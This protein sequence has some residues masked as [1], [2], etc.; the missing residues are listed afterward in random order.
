MKRGIQG[1][2]RREQPKLLI[3]MSVAI[4][5]VLESFRNSQKYN[6]Y[7]REISRGLIGTEKRADVFSLWL[8]L[9]VLFGPDTCHSRAHESRLS[10]GL[11]NG[12][13]RP[14]LAVPRF[15]MEGG[16]VALTCRSSHS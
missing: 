7:F 16:K 3:T 4:P 12:A 5:T 14:E 11:V 9:N 1:V 10:T 8:A 15:R 2:T 6:L 13:N